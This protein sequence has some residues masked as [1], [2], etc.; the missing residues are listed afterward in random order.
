ME[1][2]EIE[3][4]T[5][6]P[7]RPREWRGYDYYSRYPAVKSTTSRRSLRRML[8][9]IGMYTRMVI[10][11]AIAIIVGGIFPL[12]ISYELFL[13]PLVT[14]TCNECQI[15]RVKPYFEFDYVLLRYWAYWAL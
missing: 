1:K 2:L 11:G 15:V 12:L 9:R 4:Q 10:L 8:G 13:K 7:E 6:S 3:N 5:L 14:I